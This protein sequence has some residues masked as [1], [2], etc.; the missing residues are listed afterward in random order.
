MLNA[1]TH[2]HT[3]TYA[4][5]KKKT[6]KQKEYMMKKRMEHGTGWKNKVKL[7]K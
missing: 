1:N 2:T 3:H 7:I 4:K 5:Q 6:R